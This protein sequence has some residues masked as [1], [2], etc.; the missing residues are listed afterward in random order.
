MK[1]LLFVSFFIS[2]L[3]TSCGQEK[4]LSKL[5]I[6]IGENDLQFYSSDDELS[7]AIG[8]MALGCTATHIG[9]G[10]VLT[11]GHC[12]ETYNCSASKY[13]VTWNYRQNNQRGDF[14]SRCVEV[15]AT[16]NSNG[17]D[18]AILRYNR[19]PEA[20][21]D[22]NK[23]DKPQ[24]GDELTILSHPKG[25]PLSWSGWCQHEGNYSTYKFSYRCD[26]QGGSSGAV[27]LNKNLEVVGIHNLGSGSYQL[28]AGTYLTDIPL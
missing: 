19:T 18:Y 27:V 15:L 8:K 4:N 11:A 14:T 12:V 24:R 23:T 26:T 20:F 17:K 2:L 25:S 7:Q 10:I 6:I 1:K 5:K 28:N 3:T 13:N 9:D 22:V 21:L 16:K